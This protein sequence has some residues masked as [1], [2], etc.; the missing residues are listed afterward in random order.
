MSGTERDEGG[1]DRGMERRDGRRSEAD[2]RWRVR[3]EM[4]TP[5]IA[6]L[7]PHDG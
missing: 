5:E 3:L 2:R 6:R 1:R 7:R 4:E